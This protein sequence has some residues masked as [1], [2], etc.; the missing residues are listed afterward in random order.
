MT[1]FFPFRDLTFTATNL[2]DFS[3]FLLKRK[4]TKNKTTLVLP[5]TMNEITLAWFSPFLKQQLEQFDYL[6]TDG[7]PLVWLARLYDKKADRVY[8]PDLMLRVLDNGQR[9][10]LTHYLY[11]TNRETL[12]KLK[13]NILQRFS[14]AKIVGMHAP[15]YRPLSNKETNQVV[16]RINQSRPDFIWVSLGGAK[17]VEWSVEL[18]HKLHARAIIPVGAAFDFI[19]GRKSQAPRWLQQLGLEWFFRLLTEPGRLWKRYVLQI[20]VFLVLWVIEVAKFFLKKV[21]KN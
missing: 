14:K 19:A 15:P 20:P 13:I 5:A 10:G 2:Q 12:K 11:G 4:K 1:T 16:Q 7:M 21:R 17:Q 18:K 6:V 8:G 3:S 9:F